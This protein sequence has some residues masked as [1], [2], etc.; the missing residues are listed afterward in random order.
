M[1]PTIFC[2][3]SIKMMPTIFCDHSIKMMP[4][5]SIGVVSKDAYHI[6]KG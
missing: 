3:H 6:C 5:I 2:D 4:T 1:I